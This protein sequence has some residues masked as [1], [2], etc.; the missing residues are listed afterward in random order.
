MMQISIDFIYETFILELDAMSKGIFFLIILAMKASIAFSLD[1]SKF[2]RYVE[3]KKLED[4]YHVA[5][6][7]Y[8]VKP[9]TL[10]AIAF[11]ESSGL[12]GAVNQSENSIG[13]MQIHAQHHDLLNT[14]KIAKNQ[15][16]DGCQNIIVG[17]WILSHCEII[18]TDY[19]QQIGCYN[20]GTRKNNKQNIRRLDY[21]KKIIN[22]I[23]DFN[24]YDSLLNNASWQGARKKE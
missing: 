16:F 23:N 5:G 17:A 9:K 19:M 14:Y 8:N 4:C 1:K 10:M 2:E 7:F 21:A 22:H 20:A 13:L 18:F 24:H 3:M 12:P 15:L 6:N 11:Q